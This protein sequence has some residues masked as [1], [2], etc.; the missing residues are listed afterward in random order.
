M[1]TDPMIFVRKGRQNGLKPEG[2]GVWALAATRSLRPM[3]INTAAVAGH[4]LSESSDS[5]LGSSQLAS[6]EQRTARTW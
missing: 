1:M 6:P 2:R 3:Q 4:C 5:W